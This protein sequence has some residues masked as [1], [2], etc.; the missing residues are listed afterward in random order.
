MT[1]V[2]CIQDDIF[3]ERTASDA[4]SSINTHGIAN[5]ALV[6]Y[7]CR[8]RLELRKRRP[9]IAFNNPELLSRLSVVSGHGLDGPPGSGGDLQGAHDLL[10]PFRFCVGDLVQLT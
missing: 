3:A 4:R 7:L 10:K 8:L 6:L 9:D 2:L 5:F 1:P